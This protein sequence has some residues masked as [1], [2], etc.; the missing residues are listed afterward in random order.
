MV[1]VKQFIGIEILSGWLHHDLLHM[2]STYLTAIASLTKPRTSDKETQGPS[3]L[4]HQLRTYATSRTKKTITSSPFLA[5]EYSEL[6]IT[7]LRCNK[8]IDTACNTILLFVSSDYWVNQTKHCCFLKILPR[9]SKL[10]ASISAS[11]MVKF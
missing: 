4:D 7:G 8:A 6:G 10:D 1:P 5:T 9:R 11:I 2:H 3:S